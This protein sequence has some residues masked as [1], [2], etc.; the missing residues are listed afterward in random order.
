M[1]YLNIPPI[2][3]VLS[4]ASTS[5][6]LWLCLLGL[7]LKAALDS[8]FKILE[9]IHPVQRN[10]DVIYEANPEMFKILYENSLSIHI[11]LIVFVSVISTFFL[12]KI[13][14]AQV[15]K[16][17]GTSEARR[18]HVV[19]MRPQDNELLLKSSAL[20]TII[21]VLHTASSDLAFL[22]T[23]LLT[24][25]SPIWPYNSLIKWNGL[26]FTKASVILDRK[27]D[28]REEF[29]VV[30]TDDVIRSFTYNPNDPQR[31]DII[32]YNKVSIIR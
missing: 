32:L 11:L 27:N 15:N 12:G 22:A 31:M 16:V 28:V 26:M 10:S 6:V 2:I 29:V 9:I 4:S 13:V 17:V 25:Y 5:L 14:K 1:N 7:E 18:V 19:K 20:V 3:T 30:T 8:G 23:L 24:F 21:T